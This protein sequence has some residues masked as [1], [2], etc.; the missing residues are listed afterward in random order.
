MVYVTI[1]ST[2]PNRTI[3]EQD[4]GFSMVNTRLFKPGTEPYVLPS[5]CEQVFYSEAPG[6]QGWSFFV[7]HDPRERLIKYNLQEGNE[8]GLEEEDDDEDHD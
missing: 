7:R 3:I 8:E 1:E 6:K 2:Y 4:N 5:Q